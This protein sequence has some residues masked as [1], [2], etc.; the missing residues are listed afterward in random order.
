MGISVNPN[1]TVE[2]IETYP[3]KP[4]DWK[5]I[6]DNANIPF[7]KLYEL[8]NKYN[9]NI[10][11]GHWWK[12]DWD[13]LDDDLYDKMANFWRSV[14]RNSNTTLN[15][16]EKHIDKWDWETL[17]QNPNLTI[18]FITKYKDDIRFNYLSR[19]KFYK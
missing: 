5:R 8:A 18:E 7:N 11:F 9:P 14:G 10:S 3:N 15:I 13:D 4:W 16:I 2:F 1:I 17:S 6:L 12:D 19:N